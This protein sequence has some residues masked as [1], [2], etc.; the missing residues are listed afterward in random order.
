MS[1]QV[2]QSLTITVD[3]DEFESPQN[4]RRF[5]NFLAREMKNR[6]RHAVISKQLTRTWAPLSKAYKEHKVKY[7]LHDGA[8]AAT[9]K[10]INSLDYRVSA[11]D[12]PSL[13]FYFNS[14]YSHEGVSAAKIAK[15]LEYGTRRIPPRPL[16]RPVAE[17]IRKD[18]PDLI[19]MWHAGGAP[20][21]PPSL[22]KVR[23][24]ISKFVNISEERY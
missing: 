20:I 8:W 18:L 23:A 16:F 12:P 7:G 9:Y 14:S 22:S 24:S 4:L 15:Y 2:G 6:L 11:G 21:H 1:V 17:S 13:E 19:D 3:P 10:L 5:F